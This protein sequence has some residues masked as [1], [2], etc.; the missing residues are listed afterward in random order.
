VAAEGSFVC[1]FVC[2][3]NLYIVYY[4]TVRVIYIICG[5]VRYG[6]VFFPSVPLQLI[7]T[8]TTQKMKKIIKTSMMM[9]SQVACC[10][11][12]LVFVETFYLSVCVCMYTTF[13]STNYFHLTPLMMVIANCCIFLK[14]L[15]L[16][17][18]YIVTSNSSYLYYC[19]C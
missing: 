8:C 9:T 16:I 3:I 7:T 19:C 6:C 13:P 15:L 2:F 11:Y 5:G 14:T 1:L 18:T 17:L 10:S 4:Y 12:M